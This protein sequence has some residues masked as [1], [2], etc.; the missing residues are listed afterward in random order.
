MTRPSTPSSIKRPSVV[1]SKAHQALKAGGEKGSSSPESQA[2]NGPSSSGDRRG[3][4]RALGCLD[5][6]NPLRKA[7]TKVVLSK[8]FDNFILLVILVNC[9]LLALDVKSPSFENSKTYEVINT[10]EYVFIVIFTIEMVFKVIAFGFV[11]GEGT[12]LRDYWNGLDFTVVLL[13]YVAFMG[14][15]NYT[16]IR[17]FR[18]LRPLRTISGVEG[19]RKLVKTLLHSVPTLLDVLGLCAFAFSIFGIIAVQLFA[20]QLRYRCKEY[21]VD[22]ATGGVVWSIHPDHDGQPCSG[23]RIKNETSG[24][25]ATYNATT[26]VLETGPLQW[27]HGLLKCPEDSYCVRHGNPNYGLTSFDN[28]LAAF[29]TIFQSISLEGWTDVMYYT[30]DAVSPWVWIYFIIMIIFCSFFTV[31]LTLAVLY[32][33]F[34][35]N[36]EDI[37]VDEQQPKPRN[38]KSII[39]SESVFGAAKEATKGIKPNAFRQWFYNLQDA[40]WF[41]NLTISFIILNTVIMAAEFHPLDEDWD[42]IS[43]YFNLGFTAYFF[44]EMIVKLIGL[45][46]R[47]YIDDRM[48]VFDGIVVIIS[49]LEVVVAQATGTDGDSMFSVFRAFRLLRVFRLARSWKQLNKIINTIFRSV[50]NIAYLTCI[51]VLFIFIFALLGKEFFGYKFKSCDF[52]EGAKSTCPPGARDCPDHYDC[53]VPCLDSD[54][55]ATTGSF[56]EVEN[57]RYNGAAKCERFCGEGTSSCDALP[58]EHANVTCLAEVGHADVM[59]YNFDD[60]FSSIISIFQV[61]TGENWNEIMYEAVDKTGQDAV[62]LYFILLTIVGNYIVLNLF[63]AIL[64][65]NFGEDPDIGE[66]NILENLKSA[67]KVESQFLRVNSAKKSTLSKQYPQ[68][69]PMKPLICY[70][71]VSDQKPDKYKTYNGKTFGVVGTENRARLF[72]FDLV[73]SKP[74]EY[75]IIFLIV[76]SSITLALDAPTLDEDS[77]FKK[78]LE[79]LDKFFTVAF[80]LEVVLKVFAYGLAKGEDAYLKS[81][82]NVLD[83]VIA[84]IGAISWGLAG[85]QSLESLRAIRTVRALRP[86]KMASRA[87]GM[88]VVVNALFAS[89]P[90][91]CNV[92]LVCLF[93]FVVFAIFG[94]NLFGG[95]FYYC[96]D[97]GSG[98]RIDPR[99]ILPEN[100]RG[101]I[102]KDWCDVGSHI[103]T[104]PPGIE[105][106]NI[107]H[108][109]SNQ[110]W[111]FDNIAHSLLTLFEVATLE[112]WL[113]IMYNSADIV[114]IDKQPIRDASK[115]MEMFYVCFIIVGGFFL[116]NLFV[117]VTIEK[118]SS[119]QEKNKG[120]VFLT[121]EQHEWQKVQKII[122]SV[123]P[124][125]EQPPP[126]GKWRKAMYRVVTSNFFEDFIMTAIFVNI[127]FMAMTKDGMS[128]AYEGAL[129][130][131]NIFFTALFT[132]EAAMRITGIGVTAYFTNEWYLFDFFIVVV[133]LLGVI[134]DF[135][136]STEIPAVSILRVFRFARIFR[137]I[138]KAKTLK[139][140]FETLYYSLP[141]LGNVGS[142]LFLF[143]FIY[144]VMGM[145]LFGKVKHGETLNRHANFESF[146]GSLLVLFRMS[147]GESWN[148]LMHDTMVNTRCYEIT[149]APTL[150][151]CGGSCQYVG[152]GDALL[153]GLVEDD[154]YVNRCG[155]HPLISVIYFCSF[156]IMCAFLLLNL[157]IA[158][159]IGNFEEASI[160]YMVNKDTV[161]NFVNCWQVLDPQ[162]T[163]YIDAEQIGE[164]VEM[165]DPP[166]GI[167]GG[168]GKTGTDGILTQLHIVIRAR[169]IHFLETLH[170]LAGRISA[171]KLPAQT[172]NKVYKSLKSRLP[173]MP[174][175]ATPK[176]TVSQYYAAI[177]VQAA[178]RGFLSRVDWIDRN[179]VEMES[180][181]ESPTKRGAE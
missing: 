140:L 160:D 1:E 96:E 123:W 82:W 80:L 175:S 174:P 171:V 14:A 108:S 152:K 8:Y 93:L 83:F 12:Y 87:E 180:R 178:I 71:Y 17:S 3:T 41:N 111:N 115:G 127:L 92:A 94:I 70:Q 154:G 23:P 116:L 155:Q 156:V 148:G 5:L 28:I 21:S 97:L 69:D 120:G 142:V 85:A 68:E 170:A 168:G 91:I 139:R 61:L 114:G 46:F 150:A 151:S 55:F 134:L 158:V 124:N 73:S 22:V 146:F 166:L 122:G 26:G 36:R 130:Y 99:N 30:Q 57:S 49:V 42:E 105:P 7:V 104:Y 133:S 44:L 121:P 117:G 112:M 63:L 169:K 16:A 90:S 47:G 118:F 15:G 54:L 76:A 86:L 88:K 125:K 109:W 20:G 51:L 77:K 89:I 132:L 138:P 81:S 107:T 177:Y 131:A 19:M 37:P 103:I 34:V 137:L 162:A 163:H 176:Y 53:Y 181:S 78:V 48:N 128:D 144:A 13:A 38:V 179:E 60:I 24:A 33:H 67:K 45:G 100:M 135:A 40:S 6:E 35:T 119:M 66:V 52:V 136:S 43:N 173:T 167:K 149:H 50:A 129:F 59:R 58:C 31:N 143:F 4:Q 101:I 2:R 153:S 25:M 164:L 18:F 126:P 32:V 157:V 11:V 39:R 161:R 98:E 74:F 62:S 95:K 106:Y 79:D 9:I 72:C 110:E 65:D 64:L 141:A 56:M 165:L 172:E 27:G 113:P 10:A 159:I 147:T 75:L 29:L 145:S 102:D 84:V